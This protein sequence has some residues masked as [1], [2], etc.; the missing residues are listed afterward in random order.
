MGTNRRRAMGTT[1]S[2]ALTAAI[3]LS[4]CGGAFRLHD[5]SKAKLATGIKDKYTKAEVLSAVE[6]E[7]KNLDSLLAE[8]LAVVRANQRL[9]VDFALLRIAD[10]STPMQVTYAKAQRRLKQ[11][12][13]SEEFK[14]AR[15]RV[16]DAIDLSEGNRELQALARSI[17]G[18]T[19]AAPPPCR[20]DVDGELPARLDL[21]PTLSANAQA[22]AQELFNVYRRACGELKAKAKSQTPDKGLLEDAL[23][24]WKEARAEVERLDRSSEEAAKDV[25]A[26]SAAYQKALDE[27][28]SA[29]AKGE[30]ITKDLQD[31]AAAA[32]KAL[33]KAK[34]AAKLV[35]A[36]N[37]APQRVDALVVLLTAAAGGTTDTSDE[38]LKKA[39]LVA[40]DIPSLAG[41][42]TAL[43][44]KARAP[45]V[46]NLLI[47]MRHQVLL[48]E[49]V[50]QLRGLAQQRADILK[51]RYDALTEERRLWLRFGDAVCSYAVV[52][53]RL[54][55]PG[56]E[57]DGFVVTAGGKDKPVA[58]KLGGTD[59]PDCGLG[60]AWNVNIRDGGDDVATRELYKALAAY[61]QA[62]AIQGTESEQTFNLIDIS[63]REALAGREAALRGWDNLVA[64]PI[65]QLDAYYQAGLKPAE[66]ADLLI[67]ALGF[68][69]IAIGVSQ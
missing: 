40:K 37:A 55:H 43:L 34:D 25:A 22:S 59:I 69:A 31:K 67:K 36:E 15:A 52:K 44:E 14:Q 47:E 64:V 30:A 4:G 26:K 48:L 63:H 6:V 60:K 27:Q 68:T 11:L 46:N 1:L 50:R 19:K 10:D 32:L 57:C 54:S 42:M 39:A 53:G 2:I 24:E 13:G 9:Q 5:E 49:H 38:K 20:P 62:L 45:S 35:E 66:I 17:K 29:S 21:D 8:E 61:L 23:S 65:S 28:K 16:L 33:E 41:D 56:V 51:A 12:Q 3:A 18:L 58:C 7:K